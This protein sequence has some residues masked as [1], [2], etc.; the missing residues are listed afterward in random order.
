MQE[1]NQSNNNE[2]DIELN[3]ETE[4]NDES[5]VNGDNETPSSETEVSETTHHSHHSHHSHHG[6]HS[7][8][9]SHRHKYHRSRKH[10]SKKKNNKLVSFLK[11][12][13]SVI[14]N[15]ISCTISV[16]L[17]VLFAFR[18][19][20][21][22]AVIDQN[23]QITTQ[24]TVQIETSVY[25]KEI[26]L[27]S[28]AV[29]TYMDPQNTQGVVDIYKANDGYKSGLNK[30][31]PLHFEY[32]VN[33]LP[34]GVTVKKVTLE[35]SENN[36]YKNPL[37]YNLDV[38]AAFVDIYNLKTGTEHYYR[39]NIELS[40]S[41]VVGAVGEFST[42]KSPR[43]LNIEGTANMR[44]IGG[45]TTI[46]GKTIRQGLLYRGTELDGAVESKYTL[47]EQGLQ[48]M[49]GVLGVRFDM[50]LRSALENPS[51]VDALGNNVVHEYYGVGM[52][53]NILNDQNK[54]N[55]RRIF[56]DLANPDNYPIY[57]HCTYGRDRTGTVCY[58]LGALL[59]MSKEDLRKDY[60]LSAFTD[61][62]INTPEFN[63]F[64][65][66]INLMEGANINEKVENYLLSIGVTAKEIQS[67]RT[68][69]LE[70]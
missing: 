61:S 69:F 14:I 43:I 2:N 30:G 19:D 70:D 26:S 22:N 64:V 25:F 9:H 35:I 28:K 15:I 41:S 48:Q 68:I 44:D 34:S 4:V 11:K 17:L 46:D 18:I 3:N 54:E 23:A 59:G 27:V 67:I 12:N 32:N 16:I 53:S 21:N 52:Y 55:L 24:S 20:N 45:W 31:L 42:V 5:E 37:V 33:G 40:N 51:G 66:N 49:I 62:Y 10:S 58:L 56:S 29:L 7:H 47:T 6:H 8:H 36:Q 1:N 13:R 63:L 38:E 57:V 60:E 50:D 65:E 39:L